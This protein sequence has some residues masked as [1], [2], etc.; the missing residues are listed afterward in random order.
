ME[1]Q[2]LH[3]R[4][5][6]LLNIFGLRSFAAISICDF[7]SG[8]AVSGSFL[9]QRC[10]DLPDRVGRWPDTTGKCSATFSF[11][12]NIVFAGGFD[13]TGQCCVAGRSSSRFSGTCFTVPV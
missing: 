12:N 7:S 4:S 10:S 3:D 9:Q 8:I 11:L 1:F 13:A 2:K 5:M 6:E